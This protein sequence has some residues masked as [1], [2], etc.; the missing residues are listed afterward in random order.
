[1]ADE[2]HDDN[3]D[4]NTDNAPEEVGLPQSMRVK[5]TYTMSA[6]AIEQ[7]RNAAEQPKPGNVGNRNAWKTGSH[8]SSFLT[9]LK[10][11]KTTC[12]QYPCELVAE[13][14]TAPGGDCLDKV[15]LLATLHTI[16][17]AIKN[18]T[19]N[20]GGFQEIAAANIANAI[21][22]LEMLQQAIIQDG[23]TIKETHPGKFGDTVKLKLHPALLALPKMIQDL[24]L[25][26]DQFL[27]TPKAQA[28]V[29][30]EQEAA[31]TIGELLGA[32]GKQLAAAQASKKEK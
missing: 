22:I 25:T 14:S 28:K 5:R 24:N 21:N 10:P 6:A 1:M 12:P 2:N 17:E 19:D 23:V 3:H 32:A 9:R 20:A 4:E 31:K 15:E 18:P 27:I 16:H 7:R 11:C 8:A 30:G 29:E 26:P 13:N